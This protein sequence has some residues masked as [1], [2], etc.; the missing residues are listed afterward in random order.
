MSQSESPITFQAPDLEEVAKLFPAYEVHSLIACGG[1]GA[2]YHATQRSLE[3]A[4]A[5]K[6]LPREFSQDEAFRVGFEAEAK[7]MARLNHPNL[8]AVYDFGEADGMLFIVMEFVSGGSLFQRAHDQALEQPEALRL[9]GDICNGLAHAH[10]HGILHRDIKPANILLDENGSPKIGD[11]GLARALEREIE[12]G[13]QIY[14]TPGYT[15]PEVIE[16]PFTID[17]RA[18]IFSVGV[19]LQELLTGQPPQAGVPPSA[20]AMPPNPR[21]NAIIRRA[22]NPD[23]NSRYA[24]AGELASD[25]RKI[26]GSAPKTLVTGGPS[27]SVAA[28]AYER[29]FS[30]LG[31][32][33]SKQIIKPK[34]SSAGPLIVVA[35]LVAAVIIA[36]VIAVNARK[37]AAEGPSEEVEKVVVKVPEQPAP[38]AEG[39]EETEFDSSAAISRARSAIQGRVSPD[40][41]NFKRDI[42]E[43]TIVF[44]RKL[45]A[46]I[47]G[48]SEELE[49]SYETWKENGYLIP[50]T[51]P[52]ELTKHSGVEELHEEFLGKQTALEK[53][54][55]RS[56]GLQSGVYVLEI[57]NQIER[58]REDGNQAAIK[59]LQDE[60]ERVRND[61][62]YFRSLMMK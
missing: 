28:R 39:P 52:R 49:R 45:S 19:L 59:T 60:I 62:G 31:G 56:L 51:I 8:V 48:L 17:H 7:V 5:I 33:P 29:P 10:E 50:G 46:A 47:P 53:K 34:P 9:V 4:V 37:S 11:F 20:S 27:P 23:P 44:E 32:A 55:S 36:A 18:D 54:L 21:L 43:N 26:V 42:K 15:A 3:R 61:S 16:P 2:V 14:G 24:S 38:E 41:E 1:M 13:E 25:L 40:I 30:A 35:L 12:E 22:T 58:L 6:I 57:E